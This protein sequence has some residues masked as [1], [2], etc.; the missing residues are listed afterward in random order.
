MLHLIE[1]LTTEG[2]RKVAAFC[3][4]DT[5]SL[6][7][8]CGPTK[9]SS[10]LASSETYHE[11]KS[12]R[13]A[14]LDEQVSEIAKQI[15]DLRASP[16]DTGFYDAVPAMKLFRVPHR[17]GKQ[18]IERGDSITTSDTE[19]TDAVDTAKLFTVPRGKQATEAEKQACKGKNPHPSLNFIE[20]IRPAADSPRLYP[21]L[22]SVLAEGKTILISM[23]T[24]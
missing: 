2:R 19:S 11:L 17:K 18:A 20:K 3:L 8:P 1:N 7:T 15:A 10:S 9:S 16:S 13:L 24:L 6:S 5:T 23:P 21:T 14:R 4:G 12:E 22:E